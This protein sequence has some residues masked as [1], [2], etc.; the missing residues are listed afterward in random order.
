MN[1]STKLVSSKLKNIFVNSNNLAI[2]DRIFNNKKYGANILVINNDDLIN[3]IDKIAHFIKK[4][5]LKITFYLENDKD[6]YE[7]LNKIKDEE[8]EDNIK[9]IKSID[10]N[11]YDVVIIFHIYQINFLNSILNSII[12]NISSASQIYIYCSLC[13][14]SENIDK[15]NKF[16]SIIKNYVN[17]NISTILYYNDFVNLLN[18]H[19]NLRIEKYEIFKVTDYVFYGKNKLYE[20][21]LTSCL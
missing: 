6:I 5:N 20:F 12:N 7:F 4:Y 1:F 19:E 2:Y 14:R 8:Y 3:Q 10:N 16:R 15:K 11:I 13:D 18:T 21:I 17:I 9:V